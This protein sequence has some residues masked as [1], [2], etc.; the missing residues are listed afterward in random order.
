MLG[1]HHAFVDRKDPTLLT[2]EYE[3]AGLFKSDV[4]SLNVH[5]T[6]VMFR[7]SR[8]DLI[9]R[10]VNRSGKT[11]EVTFAGRR[12]MMAAPLIAS[13]E[14]MK[15]QAAK[16]LQRHAKSNVDLSKIRV[17]ITIEGAW[18]RRFWT[19][20]DGWQAGIYQLVAARWFVEGAAKKPV[21]FGVA[22]AIAPL[23]H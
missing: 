9:V 15:G 17:P 10:A 14:A 6:P 5:L 13:L 11:F 2:P 20:A 21:G 22:P 4:L 23:I 8:G 7:N 16:R 18:R 19:D 12:V 3:D 1:Q